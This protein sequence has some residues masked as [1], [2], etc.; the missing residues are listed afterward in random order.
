MSDRQKTIVASIAIIA[1]MTIICFIAAYDQ[2]FETFKT[3]HEIIDNAETVTVER[4]ANKWVITVT[5]VRP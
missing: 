5:E 3:A 2:R 4:S 1:V